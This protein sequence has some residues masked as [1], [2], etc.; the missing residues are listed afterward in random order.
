MKLSQGHYRR[1][2]QRI[3]G[4]QTSTTPQRD[5]VPK[6]LRDPTR[7]TTG[8]IRH[9]QSH[10][11]VAWAN[12]TSTKQRAHHEQWTWEWHQGLLPFTVVS[13]IFVRVYRVFFHE[14]WTRDIRSIKPATRNHHGQ[15]TNMTTGQATRLS[16]LSN[17]FQIHL[18]NYVSREKWPSKAALILTSA[19][20]LATCRK[21]HACYADEKVSH[22]LH[23]SRKMMVLTSKCS[24][25]RIPCQMKSR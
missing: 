20:G 25:F 10:E 2:F 4:A 18:I 9:A 22:V 13:T 3:H 14:K 23:V 16:T 15:K 17:V 5:K 12:V 6:G 1:T 24:G 11:R 19:N 21:C 7:T 8:V